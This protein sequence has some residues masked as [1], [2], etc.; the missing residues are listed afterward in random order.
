MAEKRCHAVGT[1]IRGHGNRIKIHR[2]EESLCIHLRSVSDVA[3]LGVGDKENLRIIAPDIVN[4]RVQCPHS[5]YPVTFIECKVR[6]VCH[7]MGRSRIE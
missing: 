2:L 1:H 7:A 6:L 3:P 5:V 4:C